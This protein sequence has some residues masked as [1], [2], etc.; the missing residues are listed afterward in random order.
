MTLDPDAPGRGLSG[1]C[2]MSEWDSF[3]SFLIPA[4][5]GAFFALLIRQ[6]LA[7]YTD[8]HE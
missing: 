4:A 5:V 7:I 6:V 8:S 1:R 3:L 2:R